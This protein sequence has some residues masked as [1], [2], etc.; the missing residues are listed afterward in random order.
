MTDFT[1]KAW[2]GSASKYKDTDAY[3]AACL[4]DDN[5][6][7]K[8]KIQ[9]LCKLPIEEPDGTVNTNGLKA[10]E[11]ALLGAH[12]GVVAVSAA[13]K[14]AAAKKIVSLMEQAKMTPGDALY[15]LAGMAPP[16]KK[17]G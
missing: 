8:Q 4:I 9:A 6:S 16:T 11:G 17:A 1:N 5:P 3:C 7:G 14:K 12:G 10:A 15:K 13:D 2:D